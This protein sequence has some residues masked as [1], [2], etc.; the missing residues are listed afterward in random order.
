MITAVFDANVLASGATGFLIPESVVGQILRAWRAGSVELVVSDHIL[1]ELG[2]TLEKPYFRA[3]LTLEQISR[4]R[5]LLQRR[6]TVVPIIVQVSGVATHPE[7]D[8]ILAT[9]ASAR[10]A[11]LVTGDAR[12]RAKVPSYQGV[13]LVS[14]R[15]F[16]AV[17]EEKAEQP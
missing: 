7:D 17:L 15:E 1:G 12:L 6:A 16:L 2:R 14:P 5:S 4:Y 9:A 8:L 3:R 10:T 13:R 11:Y